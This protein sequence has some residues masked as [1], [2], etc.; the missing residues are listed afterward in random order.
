MPVIV[1]IF[2]VLGHKISF[3][4]Q[5]ILYYKYSNY[6]VYTCNV[7]GWL[8]EAKKK[9]V[10]RPYKLNGSEPA[11]DLSTF[12]QHGFCHWQVA[13]IHNADFETPSSL[14]SASANQIHFSFLPSF[15]PTTLPPPVE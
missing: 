8:G 15:L 5:F 13:N 7:G 3:L 9:V 6:K 4:L 12:P 1:R 10:W 2:L 11:R 14:R